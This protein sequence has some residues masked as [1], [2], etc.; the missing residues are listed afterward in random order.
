MRISHPVALLSFLI[1][2]GLL[3]GGL[4]VH[5][6]SRKSFGR[7]EPLEQKIAS[8]VIAKTADGADAEFL[9]ILKDQADFSNAASLATKEEKGRFVFETLRAKTR[10]SQASLIDFLKQ[11]N[12]E[13][14]TFF[15][16]N[17]ILVKG[18]RD[19]VNEIAARNDVDRVVGNPVIPG[20]MPVQPEESETANL[21]MGD[22]AGVEPGI[23]Y[24]HAPEVW[25]MGF[26]G[27]GIVI[28]GQDTGVEWNHPALQNQYRGWDGTS[29]NHDYNWHDSVHKNGGSC[30]P[31][32]KM[33][34]DDFDHGTHTA[35]TA[36]G[37]D[38]GANQIG[39]APGAKF[40]ACR[41]M[42]RGSGTPASY[43]ECF[44]FFLAP[45]PV[46][47]SSADG[48]PAKA[49][50]VTIN[51]W[52]CP[53]SE[54]CDPDTLRFA[55]E[56]HRAAGIFTVVSAGNDGARGCGSVN[57]PPALYDAVY[58]VGAIDVNTGGIASFSSRGPVTVDASN[59]IKPDITAPGVSVRSSIRGGNY[60][61][62]SGTSMASPHTAG[63]VALLWSTYPWLRGQIDLT[64][65]LL[66]ESAV[67]VETTSC[68]AAT[69]PG[70]VPN[71]VFG[72]GRLDIKF[73]VDL[74]ST[75]GTPAASALAATTVNPANVPIG[76]QGGTVR[77]VV[78][79]P[80]TVTWRAVSKDAW[81]VPLTTS[82]VTGSSEIGI[83]VSENFGIQARSAKVM[84]A[85]H[86]VTIT[87]SGSNLPFAVSGRIVNG[88]G[89]GVGKVMLSFARV[90][91]TGEI[92]ASVQTG[93]DG[94]WKQSGFAPGT[95]YRAFPSGR[96][97]S[98]S[99][100]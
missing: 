31:D 36:V 29:A 2:T 14:R 87:Q 73:A 54:G 50:D 32:S 92:P 91:G 79:T 95:I 20:M 61:R 78:T 88:I 23:N 66:N 80:P 12:V 45:Y 100:A 94:S 35:G 6:K 93:A 42:D 22:P 7:Q 97:L 11:R 51:S 33:P 60:A 99:P 72:F 3:T 48:N 83:L 58:S 44:E 8:W 56:A 68:A 40:I 81:I 9:V 47:A 86:V 37:A 64:E 10:I 17:A 24:I 46:G 49:P 75:I 71:N 55:V 89:E 5:A 19:L 67:R 43:L 74:A 1:V 63:A 82:E 27:Q 4:I 34:C 90:S 38:G 77:I 28:G 13:Y 52:G 59:R 65:N 98:F 21:S 16:I 41:N 85:G 26:I 96:R 70:A 15:V 53:P 69:S 62:L 39:V 57:D 76:A 30:G 25:S 18:S 84:I